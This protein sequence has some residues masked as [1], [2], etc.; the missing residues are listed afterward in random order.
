M[1]STTQETTERRKDNETIC[2]TPEQI[3]MRTILASAVL[4]G[5]LVL[6]T[7]SHVHA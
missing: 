7:S 4:A 1:P 5:L 2:P 3:M 6:L